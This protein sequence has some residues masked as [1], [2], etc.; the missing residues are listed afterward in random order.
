MNK[1][2]LPLY[3]L[4]LIFSYFYVKSVIKGIPVSVEDKIDEKSVEVKR[5]DVTLTVKTPTFT[6]TYKQ[7][8]KTNKT[9]S[10][11]LLQVREN[12]TDFTFDRTAY[13]YGSQLDHVN[14]IKA[15]D[16]MSWKIFDGDNDITS[17]MDSIELVDG[18]S[19]LLVYEKISQ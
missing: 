11:L 7:E 19:Y 10:D 5:V 9:V 4:F 16:T 3:I 8:S 13:S 1:L 17:K 2:L 12:N 18:K 14:N 6:K 15:T